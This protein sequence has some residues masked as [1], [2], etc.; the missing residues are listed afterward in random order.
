[1]MEEAY[2]LQILLSAFRIEHIA[3]SRGLTMYASK[4]YPDVVLSSCTLRK[5]RFYFL[6]EKWQVNPTGSILKMAEPSSSE[7][8]L[9][10][11]VFGGDSETNSVQNH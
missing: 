10:E 3:I 4:R 6:K 7:K 11:E 2:S 9:D 5:D 8:G 1:M